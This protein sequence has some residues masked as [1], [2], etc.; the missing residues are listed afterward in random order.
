VTQVLWRIGVDEVGRGC[1]A[2]DVY[3]AG[4]LSPIG[5][6]PVSG[7]TDSKKM[8]YRKRTI[9]AAELQGHP[10]IRWVIAT[11]SVND[12]NQRGIVKTVTECF[13]E[14]VERLLVDPPG[15]V[16]DIIV[17]GSDVLWP[18]NY[19]G[20]VPS[21]FI[22]KADLNFWQVSA[23]SVIAKTNRDN[24]MERL[25]EAC[26]G[27]GW[28]RNKGYGTKEHL[29]GLKELGLTPHHRTKFSRTALRNLQPVRPPPPD[30]V[31]MGAILEVVAEPMRK[32]RETDSQF[33]L[34][35]MGDLL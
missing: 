24:Y 4:V 2:G 11:R 6:E 26:P 35:D 34:P 19:Y 9:A 5:L 16:S 10:E 8:T 21:R 27:Y 12:I 20:S 15:P 33:D 25:G 23:A 3:T 18:P 31:D 28:E 14:C 7:V 17:D 1:L 32:K 13:R 29:I 30:G 22:A